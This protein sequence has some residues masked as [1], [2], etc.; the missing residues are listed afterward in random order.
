LIA[1]ADDA[2]LLLD[3]TRLIWRRWNARLPSGIDRVC[4]AYLN[5]FGFRSQAVIQHRFLRRIFDRQRSRRLFELLERR[6]L[7]FRREL[8][9]ELVRDALRSAG[10][11]MGRIYLN[12]GHTGLN[13]EGFRRWV[14]AT[15][16]RPVYLIHD[17]IP[18]THPQFCRAGEADKH[19]DRMRTMLSTATGV[20]GNSQATLD[21]L[22][23]FARREGLPMPP[24]IAAWLGS[25]GLRPAASVPAPDCPTFVILGTIEARKNHLMILRIWSR[26]VERLGERAPRLLV[27][28]HRGWEADEVFHLLDHDQRLR[29]H[30]IELNGCS[31]KELAQHLQSARAL[32]FP[33][34]ME[35]FG[36]P[37]VEA[38][39]L[40]VPVAASDLPVFREFG[41]DIP[42]YLN[43]RDE[44]G[45]ESLVLDYSCADSTSRSAQ[46]SRMQGYRGPTWQD[47][48]DLVERFLESLD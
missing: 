5:H 34:L 23:D 1:Q 17:L 29:G 45:W 47:H 28:G 27:I 4:L 11:G 15:D 19:R 3:V 30:V 42:V 2:P 26:L 18:I 40:G 20:I 35:G 12:V 37:L 44:S 16:T 41:G 46:L 24:S 25:D 10:R 43:P 13:S 7:S 39:G 31:D 14:K 32:L 21:E 38:L 36:L 9:I 6:P 33:T 8:P 48:F 22:A